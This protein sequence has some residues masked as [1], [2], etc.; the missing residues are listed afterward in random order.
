MPAFMTLY[1][2]SIDP[3]NRDFY[4]PGF[5]LRIDGVG[6]PQGVLRD[7]MEVTYHDDINE[8]DG[9][10][11]MRIREFCSANNLPTHDAYVM[12]FRRQAMMHHLRLATA[13]LRRQHEPRLLSINSA[14]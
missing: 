11:L 10:G 9:F 13:R 8:I 5:E 3:A 12:E 1:D 14:L 2:E 7:V 4:A 6:L